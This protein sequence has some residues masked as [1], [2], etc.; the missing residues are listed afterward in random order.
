MKDGKKVYI[1]ALKEA[2]MLYTGRSVEKNEEDYNTLWYGFRKFC[3]RNPNIISRHTLR[4][5]ENRGWLSV[6]Q[7]QKFCDYTGIPC[8]Q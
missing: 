1:S 2:L 8:P 6:P 4:E 7:A 5:I 3:K